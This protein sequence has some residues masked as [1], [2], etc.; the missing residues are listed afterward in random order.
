MGNAARCAGAMLRRSRPSSMSAAFLRGKCLP[1]PSD[2]TWA[3]RTGACQRARM[4]SI[5]PVFWHVSSVWSNELPL[6]R[7]QATGEIDPVTTRKLTPLII[8]LD[9]QREPARR[10]APSVTPDGTVNYCL[11]KKTNTT[12]SSHTRDRRGWPLSGTTKK[13]TQ[14]SRNAQPGRSYCWQH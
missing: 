11:S 8:D 9:R 7:C 4:T 2:A 13:G 14:C 1:A 12:S 6:I 5:V 10:R 3:R